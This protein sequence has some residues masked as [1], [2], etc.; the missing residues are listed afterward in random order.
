MKIARPRFYLL[1]LTSLLCACAGPSLQYKKDVLN[2]MANQKFENAS[3]KIQNNSKKQYGQKN[4]VLY[5]LDLALAHQASYDVEKSLSAFTQAQNLNEE[6][7]TKSISAGIGSVMINDNTLPYKMPMYEQAFT[8]FFTAMNYLAQDNLSD[9]AVEMRKAVFFL[10]RYRENTKKIYNDEPFVQYFASMIFEESGQLSSARIARTNALNAYENLKGYFDAQAPS[11]ALPADYKE[12]G[13]LVF[14][15]YSGK[16]PLKI[17]NQISVSWD[18]LGFILNGNNSLQGVDKQ[19]IDAVFT[20]LYGQTIAISYPSYI[21][22]PSHGTASAL[23]LPN[24]KQIKTTPVADIAN[25]A[26]LTLQEQS[27]SLW[28][29]TATRA[30]TKFILAKQAHNIAKKNSDNN[31]TVLLV[32]MFTNIFNTATEQ[33]DTRSWFLLPAQIKMANVFLEPGEYDIDFYNYDANGVPLDSYR[34]EKVK[35][36]KGQRTYLWRYSSK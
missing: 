27:S 9:A 3:A 20:G 30:A 34:F 18:R 15:H 10:D 24:G 2:L 31:G 21:D 8:Y 32:D 4:A 26:K 6:L 22:L 5:N 23:V 7:F 16:S 1:L 36:K 28:A 17:S 29:R 12:L 13:E 35:I 14:F 11:S 33:A 19:T 25:A